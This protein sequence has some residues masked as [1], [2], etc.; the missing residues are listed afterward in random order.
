[1]KGVTVTG[2]TPPVRSSIDRRS[3]DITKDLN[4]TTGTLADVLRSV[5]ALSVDLQG[6][7]SIRGDSNVTILVDGKPSTLFSGPGRS[8]ALQSLPADDFERVEVITNPSAAFSPEGTGGIVNLISKKTRKP[9][10]NGSIRAN[11]DL[12]GRWNAGLTASQK[13]DKLTLSLTA[14]VRRERSSPDSTETRD[15]VAT[16]SAPAFSSLTTT[17]AVDSRLAWNLRGGLDYDPNAA[18][19]FSASLQYLNVGE[20]SPSEAQ[21]DGRDASGALNQILDRAGLSRTTF[22]VLGFDTSV[23]RT[24]GRDDHDLTVDLTV[25]RANIDADAPYSDASALPPLPTVFDDHR[26]SE[27]LTQVDLKADYER[28]MPRGGLLKAGYEL[29][30]LGDTQANDAFTAAPAPAS[31]FDPAQADAFRFERWINALYATYQQPIGKFTALAG[32]RLEDTET[33]LDDLTTAALARSHDLHAYPTLHLSYTLDTTHQLLASYGERVVRPS[34]R[35]LDPY[36]SV[37]SPFAI[38]MGN[39]DLRPEETHEFELAWEYRR[40]TDFVHAGLFYKINSGG[41]DDAVTNLG[42]DIFLYQRQ[43][44]VSSRTGGAELEASGQVGKQ[45]SYSLSGTLVWTQIDASTLGLIAPR[46]SLSANGHA[47]VTWQPGP[48]DMVQFYAWASGRSLTAEGYASPWVAASLGYRHKFD[49]RLSAF[50][51]LQDVFAS[52]RDGSVFATPQLFDR[53]SIN[54][55]GRRLFLGLAYSFG[56]GPKRDQAIELGAP[57]GAG[58]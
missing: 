3:Y 1:V 27:A 38:R 13:T 30:D 25:S 43:N 53:S 33:N 7:V 15:G 39:P 48:K 37:D 35:D 49:D 40:R 8:L 9:G 47:V 10:R 44:L 19:R 2:T 18:T 17:R 22:D 14:G 31:P 12:T 16:P 50:A 36:R 41:F 34:P 5:P 21:T 24:F 55:H 28:P 20:R 56:A 45:L 58:Q 51:T 52:D 42:D 23:K 11:A 32:L 57:S 29:K 46:A 54:L 4:A 26:F 6:N